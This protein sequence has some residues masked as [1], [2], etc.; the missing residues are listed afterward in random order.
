MV[1]RT[2]APAKLIVIA[3]TII[4]FLLLSAKLICEIMV[5]Q[6]T[7]ITKFRQDMIK[8]GF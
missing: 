5:V 6:Q 2:T 4:F 1:K 7:K 3:L 8:W